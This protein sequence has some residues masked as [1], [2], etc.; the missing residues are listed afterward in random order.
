VVVVVPVFEF[1][2]PLGEERDR[3]DLLV[4]GA[5]AVAGAVVQVLVGVLIF[6]LML[7]VV[8]VVV[9]VGLDG[10]MLVRG[11]RLRME[12]GAAPIP[13]LAEDSRREGREG[14]DGVEGLE[15]VRVVTMIIY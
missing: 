15:R 2:V 9:V 14:R 1:I 12:P 11:D 6:A 5:V 10:S 4:A 7:L 3:D 8:V 13:L